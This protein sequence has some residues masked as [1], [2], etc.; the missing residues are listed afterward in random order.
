M[1][2]ILCS[3]CTVNGRN[4]QVSESRLNLCVGLSLNVSVVEGDHTLFKTLHNF[5]VRPAKAQL[6]D[7]NGE[8]ANINDISDGVRLQS[9]VLRDSGG[10]CGAA[11]D[12]D[13][14][15]VCRW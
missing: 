1:V 10:K 6:Q 14:R 11:A 13:P 2:M 5:K 12:T 3:Y 7:I 4:W 8:S 9:A 15:D